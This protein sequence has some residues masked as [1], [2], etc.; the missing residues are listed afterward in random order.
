MA[1]R[2]TKVA[3]SFPWMTLD[4]SRWGIWI[5]HTH[6]DMQELSMAWYGLQNL[7]HCMLWLKRQLVV[8]QCYAKKTRFNYSTNEIWLTHL[9]HMK[10]YTNI[11][12]WMLHMILPGTLPYPRWTCK[13]TLWS[14]LDLPCTFCPIT[15]LAILGEEIVG[16]N[17]GSV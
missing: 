11:T 4:D 1:L 8:T 14:L 7:L 5:W 17:S 2:S 9:S 3:R 13:G 15:S 6:T 10:I 16:E 12:S